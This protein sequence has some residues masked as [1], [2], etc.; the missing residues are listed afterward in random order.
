VANAT[1]QLPGRNACQ[2]RNACWLGC[3]FGGYFST[4]SS[5][6]PFAQKTG[7][8]TMKTWSIASEVLYDK[9]RKRATGVRV[10]DATNNQTTDY[11]AKVVFLCAS[12]L[13][14]T[15]LLLRSATDVW[16]GGSGAARGSSGTT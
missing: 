16:P 6:L 2:Y 8:L 5:T 4:Q 9:D 1:K 15:W 13:N 14:T 7:K 10:L 12:T 3:P 11:T